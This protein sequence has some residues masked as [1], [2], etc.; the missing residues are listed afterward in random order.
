MLPAGNRGSFNNPTEELYNSYATNDIRRNFNIKVYK[1]NPFSAPTTWTYWA[2]KHNSASA[3]ANDSELDW[4]V[5]R[6]SDVLLMYCEADG[7]PNTT[8]LG[9]LNRVHTRAGLTAVNPTTIPAFEK[10]VA[11]ERRWEFALENQ[12]WFDLLRFNT[13]MTSITAENV[14]INHF[15]AM[16]PFYAQYNDPLTATQLQT[17]VTVPNDKFKLLPIPNFEIITNTINPIEQNSGY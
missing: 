4:P 9:Y 16:E 8:T 3:V 6:Y 14:M 1:P 13:T 15:T 7:T 12:R 5:L 2:A 17:K 10:A 11:D